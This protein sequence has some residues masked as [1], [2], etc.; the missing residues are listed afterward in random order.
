MSNSEPILIGI[1]VVGGIIGLMGAGVYIAYKKARG[2]FNESETLQI[3]LIGSVSG[4]II[5][6]IVLAT[7]SVITG[8]FICGYGIFSGIKYVI[9]IL[10]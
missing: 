7:L 6:N 10:S 1:N 9:N 8:I 5:S 4:V 3:A 2:T